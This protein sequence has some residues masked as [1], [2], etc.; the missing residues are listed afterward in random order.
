MIR[1]LNVAKS[2]AFSSFLLI[3]LILQACYPINAQAQDNLTLQVYV[4]PSTLPADGGSYKSIII[5][6]EKDGQPIPATQDIKIT[7]TSS[8]KDV[9]IVESE[10]TIPTGRSNVAAEFQT[11]RTAGETTITASAQ[12]LKPVSISVTT[13]AVG[14]AATQLGLYLAPS[15]ITAEVGL[16]SL[17]IVRLESSDG[18]PVNALSNITVSLFSS[19]PDVGSLDNE[20]AIPAGE[21]QVTTTFYATYTPGS[22]KITARAEGYTSAEATMTTVGN[23]PSKISAYIMPNAVNIYDGYAWIVVQL[24][25]SSGNPAKAPSDINVAFTSNKLNVTYPEG[26][27]VIRRGESQTESKLILTYTAGTATITAVA[28]G[29]PSATATVTSYP[30]N[31]G[32]PTS[33]TLLVPYTVPADGNLYDAIWV[34]FENATGY[35]TYQ[36]SLTNVQF[37]LSDVKIGSAASSTIQGLRSYAIGKFK[38]TYTPG[39]ATITAYASGWDTK[40]ATITTKGL[41]AS[42]IS[43]SINPS[44]LYADSTVQPVIVQLQDSSGNPVKAGEEIT[45]S[46]HSSNEDVGTID[47][48][49]IIRKDSDH[50]IAYFHTTDTAGSTTITP[51]TPTYT[52]GSL[53]ITTTSL[54]S[55]VLTSTAKPDRIIRNDLDYGFIF[56]QLKDSNGVPVTARSDVAVHLT[57]AN[58]DVVTVDPSVIIPEGKNFAIAE[59]HPGTVEGNS[60]VSIMASGFELA[61]VT[62]STITVETPTPEKETGA[63]PTPETPTSGTPAPESTPQTSGILQ[64]LFQ[65]WMF[66]A[67]G[68]GGGA[69]GFIFL[70]RRGMVKL[71]ILK[72]KKEEK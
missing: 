58:P 17:I 50:A 36:Y 11:T 31:N 60:T 4:S 43:L 53:T 57:S 20:V 7:L 6:L 16:T 12:G 46:L 66:I 15:S 30:I 41:L 71:P 29:Y 38:A 52:L 69:G 72:K 3:L 28:E 10:V 45:V 32:K 34:Q 33:I 70:R 59:F 27:A 25:D 65:Y 40:T 2:L 23:T 37:S 19:N 61:N 39:S 51:E 49:V 64:L 18:F 63:T 42:K 14:R 67:A 5:Q 24:Q 54:P 48:S 1:H 56:I 13:A 47:S 55:S 21:S 26:S 22:T 44:K 35:P 8:N 68:A 9:G 62:V